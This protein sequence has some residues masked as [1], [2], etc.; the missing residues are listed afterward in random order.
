MSKLTSSLTAQLGAC[1]AGMAVIV[2]SAV[3]FYLYQALATQLRERDDTD[4][5]ERVLQIQ[6]VLE[7]T[8]DLDSIMADPH[9]FHDAVDRARPPPGDANAGWRSL[10]SKQ[11]LSSSLELG[12]SMT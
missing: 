12:F 5:I 7:D 6:H 11:K 9:R 3:G 10:G 4:L 1:F 8:P 2:F